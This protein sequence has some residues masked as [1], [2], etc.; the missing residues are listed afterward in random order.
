[1]N[2]LEVCLTHLRANRILFSHSIHPAAFTAREVAAAEHIPAHEISKVVVY[3]GGTDYGMLVLPADFRV[4]FTEVGRL[5]GLPYI[6]LA[7][8]TEM[9]EMF[10]ECELGAMPPFGDLFEMPVLVDESIETDGYIAFNAGTHRDVLHLK[11]AD[12]RRL[13]NPL[14]ARFAVQESVGA[15]A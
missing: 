12:F 6:R 4:D 10:P 9:L 13:V 14:I 8:E 3:Y 2:M 15:G 11:F 1:M 7:T 5:L